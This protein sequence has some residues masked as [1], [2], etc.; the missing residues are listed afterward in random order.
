MARI[1]KTAQGKT[2]DIDNLRLANEQTIAVGNMKINARGDQLGAGGKILQTRNQTMDQYYRMHTPLATDDAVHDI[3][4]QHARQGVTVAQGQAVDPNVFD[5][6]N[7]DPS[8]EPFDPIPE[9]SET[10]AVQPQLR[11]TLA[12]SIAKSVSVQQELLDPKMHKPKGP[13]RI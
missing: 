11:G 12:D 8:G 3:Q 5:I 9:T 10:G 4:Q 6:P 13:Q 2:I 7:V 1:Y